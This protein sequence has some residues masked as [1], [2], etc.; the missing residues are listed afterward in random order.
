[1]SHIF[2]IAHVNKTCDDRSVDNIKIIPQVL[3]MMILN[4]ITLYFYAGYQKKHNQMAIN[5]AFQLT[6]KSGD[7][8][9]KCYWKFL[10]FS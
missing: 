4:L 10:Y 8:C 7:T 5:L 6:P 9:H 1:M 2:K 3:W